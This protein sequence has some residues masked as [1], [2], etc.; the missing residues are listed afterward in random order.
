MFIGRAITI[1]IAFGLLVG[2]ATTGPV[3]EVLELP[4]DDDRLA[5]AQ[6]LDFLDEASVPVE[7]SP[8]GDSFFV[9]RRGMA[10]LMS[11]VLQN[12]GLDRV[13]ATRSYAPAPGRSDADLVELALRLNDNLNVGGFAVADGAL[14]F[15]TNLTFV[16]RVSLGEVRLFLAWLDDVEIAIRSLDSASGILLITGT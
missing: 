10:T 15:E 3:S 14:I 11:P 1:V 13:I 4:G 8:S 7:M 9:Y 5:A 2:C 12:E 6:L 16:D